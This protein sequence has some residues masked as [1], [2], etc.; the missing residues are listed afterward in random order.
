MPS[1][2]WLARLTAPMM[3]G[4]AL[5]ANAAIAT[6]DPADGAYL[7][8]LR[9]VGFSWPPEHDEALVA[10]GRLVCDD[11]SW[12]WNYD[13]IAQSIHANLDSRNVTFGNVGSMVRIAHSTYCPG[14]QCW[15]GEC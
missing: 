8:Q 7:S 12:G 13:S 6:A 4:A 14:Q 5:V 2:R 11:I 15:G 10:M 9:G 1:P 3:V